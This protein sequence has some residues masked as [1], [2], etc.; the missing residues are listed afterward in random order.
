[1]TLS[2]VRNANGDYISILDFIKNFQ[3]MLDD[4]NKTYNRETLQMYIP[5]NESSE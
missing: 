5:R 3:S 1:M 4:Y 2:E